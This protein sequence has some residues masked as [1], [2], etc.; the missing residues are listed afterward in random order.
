MKSL[1]P[2]LF[3]GARVVAL[4]IHLPSIFCL[5]ENLNIYSRCE[6]PKFI[7]YF[8]DLVYFVEIAGTYYTLPTRSSQTPAEI[9]C[10]SPPGRAGALPLTAADCLPALVI[11][12]QLENAL[13]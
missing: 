6:S 8:I 7:I 5:K 3:V 11:R 9:M 13:G 10:S 2:G 1:H 12:S 4:C